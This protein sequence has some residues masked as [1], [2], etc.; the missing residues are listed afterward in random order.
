MVPVLLEFVAFVFGAPVVVD[1]GGDHKGCMVPANR[2]AG[3]CNLIG[4]QGFA[5]RLGGVHAVGT[6]LADMRFT[7]NQCGFVSAV[8]GC[9][10][11]AA[12]R[13]HI[14]AVHADDTPAISLEASRCVVNEPRRDLAVDGDTVVVVQGDELVQLPRTRQG[15]GLVADALHHAAVT[16][17]H[18]GV[19]VDDGMVWA[20]ELGSQQFFGQRHAHRVGDALAQRAGGGFHAGGDAHLRVPCGFAVQLPEVF[21]LA[22]GQV[23][24]GEV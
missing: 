13:L 15:A 24:A 4:A 11:G 20:V 9:R 7:S 8:F 14:V 16:H 17:E 3:K 2:C 12:D 19:V 21:Q 23:V 5:V 1:L 22:H 10:D 18:I 6:A